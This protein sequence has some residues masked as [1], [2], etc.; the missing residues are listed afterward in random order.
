MP[1]TVGI[2]D[3]VTSQ[4]SNDSNN[5][6]SILA[7]VLTNKRVNSRTVKETIKVVWN[8]HN[9]VSLSHIEAN[10]FSCCFQKEKD[11][12]RIQ[13]DNP[14]S[15]RG[16]LSYYNNDQKTKHM[17]KW[18]SRKSSFESKFIICGWIRWTYRM[19]KLLVI[20]WVDSFG[21]RNLFRVR[22]E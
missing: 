17:T 5:S 3:L 19:L 7:R 1:L 10:T 21:W 2:L 22:L 12:T 20:S 8:V 11:L 13:S 14:W 9:R 18:I 16:H 6:F 15:F 4:P